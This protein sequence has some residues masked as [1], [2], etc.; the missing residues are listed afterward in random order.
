M[1]ER[2]PEMK[3]M[4][5]R[6]SGWPVAVSVV[7]GFLT[8]CATPG[9]SPAAD[10]APAPPK[11]STPDEV[12]A[13]VISPV[14]T[15]KNFAAAFTPV[16]NAV[17]AAP[18]R[19]DLAWLQLRLCVATEGCDP[20]PIEARLRKLDPKNGAAWLGPLERAQ[21]HHDAQ[22]EAQVLEALGRSEYV[23]IY[24]TSLS[25]H[26]TAALANLTRKGN[27]QARA[28]YTLSLADTASWLGAIAIPSFA[29]IA[30][31]CSAEGMQDVVMANRCARV[32]Q[33]FERGDTIIGEGVG[34]GIAERLTRGTA[35]AAD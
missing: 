13:A 9:G 6:R 25:S 21:Q 10:K 16:Q 11:P 17:A 7:I 2:K 19:A 1:Y 18:D 20:T 33:V 29:S 23:D 15:P 8:A 5:A 14:G 12:V 27:P 31:A 28:V 32:G 34:L 24:W 26:L 4:P 22:A 35:A 30:T 3:P